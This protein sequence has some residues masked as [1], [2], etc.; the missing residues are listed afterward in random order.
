MSL[1]HVMSYIATRFGTPAREPGAPFL[2]ELDGTVV[3]EVVPAREPGTP[4][5]TTEKIAPWSSHQVLLAAMSPLPS[6]RTSYPT[7]DIL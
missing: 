2:P 1:G 5:I 3:Y 7:L 4:F 6:R